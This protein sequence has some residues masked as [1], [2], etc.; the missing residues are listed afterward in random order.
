MEKLWKECVQNY[1]HSNRTHGFQQ[2]RWKCT[3]IVTK[4]EVKQMCIPKEYITNSEMI[5]YINASKHF[6]SFSLN[7]SVILLKGLKGILSW[8][9][10]SIPVILSKK[11]FNPSAKALLM[12][13]FFTFSTF[14]PIISLIFWR[15]PP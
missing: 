3:A 14:F 7:C 8:T 1:Q 10:L 11:E 4:P 9:S 5:K 15:K 2:N 12:W 13:G 6:W